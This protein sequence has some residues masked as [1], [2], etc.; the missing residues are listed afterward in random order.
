MNNLLFSRNTVKELLQKDFFVEEAGI[1][2]ELI[3]N[4]ESSDETKI[5][6]K[7]MIQL[8]LRI[9]DPKKRKSQHKE[10]EAIQFDY[11]VE[12]DNPEDVAQEMVRRTH[13]MFPQNKEYCLD[14]IYYL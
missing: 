2:V 7:D 9:L 11:N 4:D 14:E 6:N 12:T 8:R 13:F 3:T 1:K 5:I 10:N